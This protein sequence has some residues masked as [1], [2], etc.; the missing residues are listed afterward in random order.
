[1][2]AWPI[3]ILAAAGL[4]SCSAIPSPPSNLS[5]QWGGPHISLLLEGG[6]GQIEYDCASGTVDTVIYPDKEGHFTA[7]GTHRTGQGGPVRVGQV[8]ISHR[9]VYS[10]TVEKEKMTFAGKLED[11]TVIGPFSMTLD[12]GRTMRCCI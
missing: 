2:R 10:G 11:G 3:L 6:L 7:T 5:G 12:H 9:A 4:S 1:M 8:F